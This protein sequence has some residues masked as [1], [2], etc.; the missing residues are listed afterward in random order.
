MERSPAN[1]ELDV[2]DVQTGADKNGNVHFSIDG[3]YPTFMTPGCAPG[4]MGLTGYAFLLKGD[5]LG[6]REYVRRKFEIKAG[7]APVRKA[8]GSDPR[9]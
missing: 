1:R 5:P 6:E 8:C 2:A 9:K 3:R 4:H 7:A